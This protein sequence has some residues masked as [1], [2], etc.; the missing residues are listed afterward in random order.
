MAFG[1]KDGE[2]DLRPQYQMAFYTVPA[3]TGR[4]DAKPE[5][6]IDGQSRPDYLP[7]I[8]SCTHAWRADPLAA[9]PQWVQL[10]FRNEEEIREIRVVFDPGMTMDGEVGFKSLVKDYALLG[11]VGGSWRVLAEV[12]DNKRRLAVHRFPPLRVS[13]VR[14]RVDATYGY[15]PCIQEIRVY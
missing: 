13:A 9:L 14:V 15:E 7:S 1:K 2:L 4:I 11:L 12:K 6:V 8:G 3:R 5:Y 10:D